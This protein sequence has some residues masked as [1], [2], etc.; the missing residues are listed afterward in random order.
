VLF[1]AVKRH[2][3]K[4]SESFL[5]R[6]ALTDEKKRVRKSAV[7]NSFANALL[8]AVVT[9]ETF[10]ISFSFAH[11]QPLP[12]VHIIPTIIITVLSLIVN[13]NI[14]YKIIKIY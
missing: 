4:G 3:K 11:S 5:S 12:F 10:E 1:L 8:Y 14:F 9:E 6:P 7:F 2:S 13:G